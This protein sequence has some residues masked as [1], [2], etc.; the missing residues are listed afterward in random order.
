M[1]KIRLLDFFKRMDS[2]GINLRGCLIRGQNHTYKFKDLVD[3]ETA[4]EVFYM[5]DFSATG[6]LLG[7][8]NI[9]TITMSVRPSNLSDVGRS[10]VIVYAD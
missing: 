7:N 10:R 4:I 2:E 9:S 3:R 5:A 8:M 6:R 1:A